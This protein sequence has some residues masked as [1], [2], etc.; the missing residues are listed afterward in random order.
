VTCYQN[1]YISHVSLRGT[2]PVLSHNPWIVFNP[3]VTLG[4][5]HLLPK[6]KG[7]SAY[8][9]LKQIHYRT[10]WVVFKVHTVY[11]GRQWRVE[12]AI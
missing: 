11:R 4:E 3:S 6:T 8:S 7:F 12:F 2:C 1:I 9:T 5:Y 10:A